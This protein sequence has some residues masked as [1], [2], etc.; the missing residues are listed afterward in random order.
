[1]RPGLTD[2]EVR[3]QQRRVNK[4]VKEWKDKLWLNG[5]FITTAFVETWEDYKEPIPSET[6]ACVPHDECLWEYM[7]ATIVF[8]LGN[9]AKQSDDDLKEAVIHELLHVVVNEMREADIKHEERVVTILT[10][11]IW[12]NQ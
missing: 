8:H 6:L 4:L 2:R 3:A 5:W 12:S 9:A 1:M 11:I 10:R 7:Q